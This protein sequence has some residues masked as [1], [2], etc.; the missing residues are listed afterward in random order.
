MPK[1]KKD[2][3][4]SDTESDSDSDSESGK[5]YN[6]KKIALGVGIGIAL[7]ISGGEIIH[8][9]SGLDGNSENEIPS[10]KE[11]L[12]KNNI[13]VEG[14]DDVFSGEPVGYQDG[15]IP[16]ENWEEHRDNIFVND[17]YDLLGIFGPPTCSRTTMMVNMLDNGG[18]EK[19]QAEAPQLHILPIHP[20]GGYLSF[21]THAFSDTHP[22]RAKLNHGDPSKIDE[23]ERIMDT[24]GTINGE[25]EVDHPASPS[26]LKKINGEWAAWE[27]IE[28]PTMDG[29][30]DWI[31]F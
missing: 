21:I 17:D 22:E 12:N 18:A 20:P 6:K 5:T 14:N 15:L 23:I 31:K 19:I 4:E 16:E 27:L 3:S 28:L 24:A 25:G 13:H 11:L 2:N 1:N 10:P 8:E 26:I 7:M 9:F 29:L 30:I